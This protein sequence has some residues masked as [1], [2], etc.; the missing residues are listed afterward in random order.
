MSK[1][2]SMINRKSLRFWLLLIS[3]QCTLSVINC[4]KIEA[5]VKEMCPCLPRTICPR[6]YGMSPIVSTFHK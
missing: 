3:L 5:P 4:D 1:K 2:N 6:S